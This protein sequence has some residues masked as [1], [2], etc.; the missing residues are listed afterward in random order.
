[1]RKIVVLKRREVHLCFRTEQ[2]AERKSGRAGELRERD[3][4]RDCALYLTLCLLEAECHEVNVKLVRA[5]L[6]H[7]V[8]W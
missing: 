3:N 8:Q 6:A 4:S 1:M 7:F 2:N 5:P